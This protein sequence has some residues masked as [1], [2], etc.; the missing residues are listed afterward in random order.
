MYVKTCPSMNS[1]LSF[2]PCC[3]ESTTLSSGLAHNV[4]V[5]DALGVGVFVKCAA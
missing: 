1:Y 2:F 4:G 5:Y 3:R